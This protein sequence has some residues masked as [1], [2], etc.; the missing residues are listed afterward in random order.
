MFNT[1][2]NIAAVSDELRS[3]IDDQETRFSNE[4]QSV[5]NKLDQLLERLVSDKPHPTVEQ[6]IPA[7][8][9]SPRINYEPKPN[10]RHQ[11]KSLPPI[12]CLD[13]GVSPTFRQWKASIM[14]KLREN[15]DHFPTERSRITHVWLRTTGLARSYL[16]PRYV[17]EN[18][19]YSAVSSMLRDLTE[20]FVTGTEQEEAKNR[21]YDSSMRDHSH[22]KESFSDFK[23][24]FIADAIEGCIA[25]SEWSYHFWTKV[26]H[27]IREQN[28]GFK[29]SWG[30]N[31]TNMIQHLT[32]VEMERNRPRSDQSS[33]FIPKTTS[34]SS[35]S[36]NAASS[37]SSRYQKKVGFVAASA[38]NSS[39]PVAKKLYEPPAT[40][41]YS[42]KSPTPFTA[43]S[44]T[45]GSGTCHN[46]GKTG[47]WRKDCLAPA[48]VNEVHIDNDDDQIALG[49]DSDADQSE[50]H[51]A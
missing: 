50:N 40:N 30:G 12:D 7:R 9:S 11:T 24:R 23:S 31:F 39:T 5:S 48:K 1:A 8:S 34:T 14:D 29:S 43:S 38:T 32:R 35:S 10:S 21:F 17:S 28:I 25:P 22:P 20:Y 42:S 26:T 27:R 16:T 13:D 6:D 18:N 51:L 37:G 3:R 45:P 33:G 15:A 41:R 19:Q 2:S 46:C 47:H 44:S 49:S 4:L 36:T